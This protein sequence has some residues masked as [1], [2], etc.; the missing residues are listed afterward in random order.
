MKKYD[1]GMHKSTLKVLSK[2]AHVISLILTRMPV[3]EAIQ[4]F[5]HA[6]QHSANPYLH[7]FY[8]DA[9]VPAPM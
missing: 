8:H 2:I 1:I 5:L 9:A 7:L 6:F 4:D 3:V